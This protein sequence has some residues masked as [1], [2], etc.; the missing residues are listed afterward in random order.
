M[1]KKVVISLLLVLS[2]VLSM[3]NLTLIYAHENGSDFAVDIQEIVVLD[4]IIKGLTISKA[5]KISN[6]G[7]AFIAIYNTENTLVA[8]DIS[9]D[10]VTTE[11]GTQTLSFEGGLQFDETLKTSAYVWQNDDSGKLTMKPYSN[12]YTYEKREIG[13]ISCFNFVDG[14]AKA[15]LDSQTNTD[16]AYALISGSTDGINETE[17]VWSKAEYTLGTQSNVIVPLLAASETSEWGEEPYI[18]VELSTMGYEGIRFSALLGATKKGPQNYKLQYSVDGETFVDIENT[19]YSLGTNKTMM[20]AFDIVKLP[21]EADNA[22]NL[23]IRIA[24]DDLSTIGGDVL[25]SNPTGGEIAV[26]NI[27]IYADKGETIIKPT[28]TPTITTSPTPTKAPIETTSPTADPVGDGIIHLNKTSIDASGIAG[29]EVDGTILTITDEGD[30]TIEG[31]LTDG[32]IKVA[33][34]SKDYTAT[35]TLNGVKV[36]NSTSAPFFGAEGKVK[37]IIATDTVNEF[38]DASEYIYEYGQNEPNACF[39]S[40]RDMTI[41]KNGTGTLN[42]NGNYNN[43]IGSKADLKINAGTFNVVAV[44]NAVK[45]NDTVTI[46]DG[47]TLNL[48]SGGD[49]IKTDNPDEAADGNGVVNIKGG[50][51]GITTNIDGDGIQADIALI[52]SGGDITIDSVGD[53]LKCDIAIEVN[54]GTI[55][56][57]SKEDGVQ[58]GTS[59]TT[60]TELSSIKSKN[61]NIIIK[62]SEDGFHSSTGTIDIESGVYDITSGEDAIQAETT[63]TINDGE[64]T[65]ISGGGSLA[66][67][68][69]ADA[70]Y[71]GL[72]GQGYI[73]INGGTFDIDSLDDSIHSNGETTINGGKFNMSSGDDGIH[74][75]T[76]LTINDGDI[77]I[78]KSYE[79]LEALT[80]NLAGG[81]INL[82]ATDDGIN[83]AGGADQ[84]NVGGGGR[85]PPFGGGGGVPGQGSG[86]GLINITGGYCFIDAAGDGID[87]NG[88]ITMSGGV[89]IVNGP[90]SSGDGA[91]DYDGS[92]VLTGGFLIASGSSGMVQAPGT[93]STQ[94]IVNMRFNSTVSKNTIVN[95]QDAEG[96]SIMTY[97]PT[98]NFGSFVMS[99]PDITK[100]TQYTVYTGGSYTGGTNENGLYTGGSYTGGTQKA[101]FTP[102]SAVTSVSIR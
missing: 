64:F 73:F 35:I 49:G 48:V 39:F 1:T 11:I 9:T 53:G 34:P 15:V 68:I 80:I 26:N 13:Y 5:S 3:C 42:V 23:Y 57:T 17:F 79:G 36:S 21:V 33:L 87:A 44:N 41:T 40:K 72:K 62:C 16:G 92:Y 10:E 22:E 14:E 55:D 43:G 84:S 78:N 100:G 28:P 54:G 59:D 2:M 77:N 45:G 7:T 8:V 91:I 18:Q 74:S 95:I 96:N 99:S 12:I 38:T 30:Y 46:A 61:A 71:K 51:I 32:Q 67:V 85:R 29:V 47:V 82:V 76:A 101:T 6:T 97:A 25:S 102:S 4:D 88:N 94:N 93:A 20:Q 19:V 60:I 63:L 24:L 31:E 27:Y 65:I 66:S 69:D 90:T 70:S 81:T 56:I 98:K 75:D 37:V 89:I 50:K 86:N 83:A 52:V 58:A